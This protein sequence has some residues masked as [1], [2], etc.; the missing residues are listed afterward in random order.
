MSSELRELIHSAAP[1]GDSR[2]I[3]DIHKHIHEIEHPTDRKWQKDTGCI[4]MITDSQAVQAVLCGHTILEDKNL[5]PLMERIT[6]KLEA[7]YMRRYGPPMPEADP[8]EWR[9]RDYNKLSDRVCNHI[10]DGHECQPP[11]RGQPW[12][13]A[14]AQPFCRY[15]TSLPK[16]T[17]R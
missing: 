6:N 11:A 7:T 1:R 9:Y 12:P 4:R 14:E 15:D 8:W 5:V 2:A 13:I 3:A 16:G 10:L 17:G